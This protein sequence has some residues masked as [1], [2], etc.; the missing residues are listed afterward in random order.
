M[1]NEGRVSII[2]TIGGSMNKEKRDA[3]VGLKRL[4]P[5]FFFESHEKS[6]DFC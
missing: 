3:G 1:W 2:G 4:I 6:I 5:A